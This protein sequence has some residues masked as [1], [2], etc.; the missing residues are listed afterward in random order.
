MEYA[1]N[2]V[3][4]PLY[5]T[6]PIEFDTDNPALRINP[7]DP[8][9]SLIIGT[10]KDENGGLY[11]YDLKGKIIKEKTIRGL[12]RPNNVDIAT[13]LRLGDKLVDIEDS[14]LSAKASV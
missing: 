6:E 14:S 13:G 3:I 11:L 4:K 7:N 1:I 12:K 2:S 10:D 8:L 9:Q 5:I